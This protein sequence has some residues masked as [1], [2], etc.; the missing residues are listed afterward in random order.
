MPA[1]HLLVVDDD[2]Q[3]AASVAAM[4]EALG[5]RTSR[6]DVAGGLVEACARIDPVVILLDL[7]LGEFDGIE[8]LQQLAAQNVRAQIVLMS[9]AGARIMATAERVGRGYGLRIAGRLEKPFGPVEMTELLDRLATG[10]LTAAALPDEDAMLADAPVAVT[11]ATL[12]AALDAG[13]IVPFYQPQLHMVS[14]RR[15]RI[16]RVEV[17]AR[18]CRDGRVIALPARFIPVAEANGLIG[19]LTDRMLRGALDQLVRWERAGQVLGASVNLS[20]SS[21]DDLALPRHLSGLADA[22]GI[23]PE[24]ITFE[25]TE[26]GPAGYRPR[27][28][29]VLARLRLRGFNLAMDDFGTGFSSL[30]Q[31]HRLPFSELK[32]DRSFVGA[33]MHDPECRAIISSSIVLAQSIGLQVCAEGVEDADTMEFLYSLGCDLAQGYHIGR[34]VPPDRVPSIVA[35]WDLRGTA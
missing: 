11:G 5:W 14:G 28:M 2:I 12:A 20:T 3:F 23:P 18:W 6:L 15:W 34:P 8:A 33:A 16:D 22:A 26:T 17:L 25:L 4:A 29:D 21:L 35:A 7:L 19:R 24:R 9:G 13:E 1:P 32:I 31:L 27:V 30:V 10:E